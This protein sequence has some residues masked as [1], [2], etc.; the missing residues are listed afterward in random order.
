M[1]IKFWNFKITYK[2]TTTFTKILSYATDD[3]KEVEKI[4]R[5]DIYDTTQLDIAKVELI[6]ESFEE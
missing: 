1:K 3:I 6:G 4:A 2:G 5:Q